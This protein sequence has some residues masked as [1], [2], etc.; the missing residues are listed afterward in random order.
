MSSPKEL[1]FEEDTKGLILDRYDRN[2]KGRRG[3]KDMGAV[4]TRKGCKHG[5]F[6]R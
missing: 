3:V 2:T 5:P 6:L 1:A 4:R